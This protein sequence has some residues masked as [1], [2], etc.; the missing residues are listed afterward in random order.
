MARL[1]LEQ[2]IANPDA[3]YKELAALHD[4]LSAEEA[5]RAQAMLVLMFANHIGDP[6]V[7]SEAIQRVRDIMRSSPSSA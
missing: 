2:R 5:L 6:E 4:G 7:L 3:F 1:H